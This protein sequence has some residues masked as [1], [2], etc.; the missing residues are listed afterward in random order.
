[1][2]E[3]YANRRLEIGVRDRARFGAGVIA[4][5]PEIVRALGARAA[6]V[7]TDPGVVGSGVAGRVVD[8]LSAAGLR[9]EV[10]DGVEPN[11][12]SA[13]VERGGEALRRFI[14]R[15][16]DSSVVVIAVGG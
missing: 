4:E 9:V 12:G 7:V 14:S 6:F 5:V 15:A 11:P 13:S 10:F 3:G 8:L 2:T 16:G 1:M